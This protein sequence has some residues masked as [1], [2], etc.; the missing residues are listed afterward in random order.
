MV[1]ESMSIRLSEELK[2]A[3]DRA[4]AEQGLDEGDIPSRAEFLRNAARSHLEE[5]GVEIDATGTTE[6]GA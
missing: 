6:A 1:K 3:I 4:R 2:S 5:L